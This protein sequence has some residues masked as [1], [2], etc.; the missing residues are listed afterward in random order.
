MLGKG[1]NSAG[2][3]QK[4]PPSSYTE[5]NQLILKM[6]SWGSSVSKI[7]KSSQVPVEGLQRQSKSCT[8][9]LF[10]LKNRGSACGG[11]VYG[12]ERGDEGIPMKQM[13]GEDFWKTA[14]LKDLQRCSW[15][16]VNH[17]LPSEQWLPK[18]GALMRA[19]RRLCFCSATCCFITGRG[20]GGGYR[21]VSRCN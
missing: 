21:S 10:P 3:E 4:L 12:Q 11:R 6:Q 16:L 20:A 17:G 15:G 5:E 19:P 14:I 9:E 7:P 2:H 18:A 8:A 13:N 1:P